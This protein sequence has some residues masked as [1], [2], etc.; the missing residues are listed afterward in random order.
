M[1]IN[2]KELDRAIEEVQTNEFAERRTLYSDKAPIP[3]RYA[4]ITIISIPA[5]SMAAAAAELI[6]EQML[7]DYSELYQH[8]IDVFGLP[9]KSIHTQAFK[10]ID[11][12]NINK[13]KAEQAKEEVN[14]QS[15]KIIAIYNERIAAIIRYHMLTTPRYSISKELA[16]LLEKRITN[17]HPGIWAAFDEVKV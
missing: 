4:S 3:I 7:K 11:V 9:E 5:F 12:N 10:N 2:K 17:I 15:G 14:T 16:A 8:V 13:I 6:E 1:D